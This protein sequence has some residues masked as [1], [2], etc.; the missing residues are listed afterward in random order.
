[1]VYITIV[2]SLSKGVGGWG[3]TLNGV[4]CRVH[5]VGWSVRDTLID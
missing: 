5:K 4:E 1:M 3:G 2:K